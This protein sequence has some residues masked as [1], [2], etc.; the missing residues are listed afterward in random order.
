M[1]RSSWKDR[2]RRLRGSPSLGGGANPHQPKPTSSV[3]SSLAS[4]GENQDTQTSIPSIDALDPAAHSIHAAGPSPSTPLTSPQSVAPAA[5]PRPP[6]TIANVSN[7]PTLPGRLWT[8]AYD[9][10]RKDDPEL[11]R[12]YETVLRS[13][14]GG[15]SSLA[16]NDGCHQADAEQTRAQM[17]Q[18]VET[19][20]KKTERAGTVKDK[21]QE[22]MH[23]VSSVKELV[24]T[25]VKHA[26]EAATAWAGVCLLLQ[27]SGPGTAQAVSDNFRYLKTLPPRRAN[28]A[29]ESPTLSRGWTG[30]GT[31][32]VAFLS[33]RRGPPGYEPNWR[34]T[35][36]PSTRSFSRIR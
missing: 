33:P 13:E 26:P 20:L 29:T 18:L 9:A 8:Q 35:L 5:H 4:S 19:G 31:Y 28:I 10:I 21:I 17:V 2:L 6:Q 32:R 36:L 27:V 23:V 24:G 34:S 11:A 14:L 15:G 7:S 12:A 25:A 3:T 30:T 16:N 22:G 1:A